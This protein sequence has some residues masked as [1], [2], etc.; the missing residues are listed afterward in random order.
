[1]DSYYTTNGM[2]YLFILLFTAFHDTHA[3]NLTFREIKLKPK[4]AFYNVNEPTVIYPVVITG[5]KAVNKQINDK[6]RNEMLGEEVTNVKQALIEQTQE[7][8][9]NMS[10]EVTYKKNG[11]LSMNIYGEGCGAY[12]SGRYTYFNFDLSTG[13]SLSIYDLLAENKID[14]F[15]NL[16]F[17]DKVKALNKYKE[18]EKNNAAKDVDSITVI[19]AIEQV[20]ENCITNVK[21]DNFSLSAFAI[22]IKDRC[23]FPHAIRS[24]EPDYELKYPYRFVLPFLKPRFQRLLLKQAAVLS[25]ADF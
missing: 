3:Q 21:L 13:K 15:R 16:V 7:G 23:E 9:I 22:E 11:I 8:L 14:S 25:K 20:D 12:C 4:P 5:N 18:Q 1:M 6:I 17:S 19:W 10:Y 24:Q 2:K